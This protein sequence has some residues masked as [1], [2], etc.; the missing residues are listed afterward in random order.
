M[1]ASVLM[2]P[3]NFMLLLIWRPLSLQVLPGF[4]EQPVE[5]EAA[6]Q[7]WRQR[8]PLFVSIDNVEEPFPH[9]AYPLQRS[10]RDTTFICL[11]LAE[12]W[13]KTVLGQQ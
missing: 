2:K 1:M 11:E 10:A 7:K 8:S 5:R 13:W 9:F 6:L 12:G 4:S 3:H